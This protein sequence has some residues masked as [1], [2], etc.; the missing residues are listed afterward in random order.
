MSSI[1]VTVVYVKVT[2]TAIR[3]SVLDMLKEN[4]KNKFIIY[5][6]ATKN[7]P[8]CIIFFYVGQK[9]KAV[10]LLHDMRAN[11]RRNCQYDQIRL[12]QSKFTKRWHTS[13]HIADTLLQ[14]VIR[15]FIAPLIN[16]GYLQLGS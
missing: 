1:I 11:P 2:G 7:S 9:S 14:L 13:L 8:D 3:N 15:Y 10:R 4:A 6:P 5:V 12:R 16:S